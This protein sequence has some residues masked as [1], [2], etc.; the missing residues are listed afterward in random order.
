MDHYRLYAMTTFHQAALKHVYITR[1]EF[2]CKDDNA[3]DYSDAIMQLKKKMDG[4]TKLQ[5]LTLPVAE[6]PINYDSLVRRGA[7]PWWAWHKKIPDGWAYHDEK[8]VGYLDEAWEMYIRETE[9]KDPKKGEKDKREQG[10]VEDE[11]QFIIG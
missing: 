4:L 11:G 8:L 9:V 7:S 10:V 1:P 2:Y 3:P 5:L 6:R